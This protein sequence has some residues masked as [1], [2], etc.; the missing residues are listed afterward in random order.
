MLDFLLGYCS[1][2]EYLHKLKLEHGWELS[3]EEIREDYQRGILR[4]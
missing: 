4:G 2:E 3:V 1:E